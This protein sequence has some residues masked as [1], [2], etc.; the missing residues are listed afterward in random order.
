MGLVPRL[1]ADSA[2]RGASFNGLHEI[3]ERRASDTWRT[4]LASKEPAAYRFSSRAP[5]TGSPECGQGWR[6]R[7]QAASTVDGCIRPLAWVLGS[8]F[9]ACGAG[10]V[11]G[12]GT[13]G[14][15]PQT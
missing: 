3:D 9:W 5:R 7:V 15:S 2:T 10:W 12:S 8:G 13:P 4:P 1:G 14:A 11:L 6:C